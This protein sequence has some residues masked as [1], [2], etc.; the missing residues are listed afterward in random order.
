MV[1]S[2]LTV[3]IGYL[4]AG[5][6]FG[7]GCMEGRPAG[8]GGT[9]GFAWCGRISSWPRRRKWSFP[10]SGL[11]LQSSQVTMMTPGEA[12]R[13]QKRADHSLTWRRKSPCAVKGWSG[14][15]KHSLVTDG[16]RTYFMEEGSIP[17]RLLPWERESAR[18]KSP[19][20]FK[21]SAQRQ[22]PQVPQG[23]FLSVLAEFQEKKAGY[24]ETE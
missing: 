15:C 11:S 22:P 1:R 24:G 5:M 16:Y 12:E 6:F 8:G 7:R 18:N 2:D 20:P 3:T 14:Y 9:L 17:R 23:G 19:S 13:L 4:K 21:K 10:R